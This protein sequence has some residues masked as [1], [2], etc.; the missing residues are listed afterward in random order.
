MHLFNPKNTQMLE[1][2]MAYRVL[3]GH[4]KE[5]K[6]YIEYFSGKQQEANNVTVSVQEHTLEAIIKGLKK[7]ASN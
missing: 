6:A 7:E 3:V 1:A 4:D 2:I 5:S